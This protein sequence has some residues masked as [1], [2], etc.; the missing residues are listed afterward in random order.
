M[1]ITDIRPNPNNPRVIRDEKF[2]KLCRSLA[3][4]PQMM[5]LRPIIIDADNVI[6][7]GNMR[8]Q[9]LRASGMQEIPDCWVKQAHELTEAQK[10]EFVIKDN[11]GFGEWDFDMLANLWDADDLEAWGL[12][13]PEM[14]SVEV[15]EAKEDDYEIPD[16]IKTDIVLG[17]LIEIGEHRLLCGDSTQTDTFEKLFAGKKADL[18][19][20]DPPYNV[21]YTGGTDKKL[22]I[23]NDNMSDG[24]FYQF[25]YDFHTAII[26]F[27]KCGGGIYVWH[28]DSEGL[29]FRRAFIESGLDLKQCLIWVKNSLV[30]GR[31]DY[32]WKHEPCLYGWKPGAAHYFTADRTNTTVIDDKLDLKKLKK[33]EMLAML[34]EIFSDKTKT[35]ILYYDKPLKNDVHPTMKPVLLIAHLIEN[36]SSQ[37]DIIADGFAGS[38]TTM[39]AAHQLKRKAY[40]VE[41]DPK[42]CQVIVDRMLQL[43]MTLIVKRN[44]EIWSV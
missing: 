26:A 7:G 13:L 33:E 32:Q 36:S 5:E 2:N 37:G 3:D 17:D 40:V 24:D 10:Q 12:D 11:V 31:Q 23:A 42:Y 27:L 21:D 6:L 4:F 18:I 34:Q 19:V 14:E 38:G 35:S 43:D 25:L 22:K 9:A 20:T 30:M 44:G 29:N 28:A 1:K 8:Y 16:N 39:V 15:A 41:Y